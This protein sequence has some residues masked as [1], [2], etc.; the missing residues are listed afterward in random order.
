MGFGRHPPGPRLGAW[1]DGEDQVGD[2]GGHVARCARCR[3]SVSEMAR[4]R[5]WMR[6]QPFFAMSDPESHPEVPSSNRRPRVVAVSVLLVLVLLVFNAPR[7]RGPER[8]SRPDVDA[9]SPLFNTGTESESRT[10]ATAEH[11]DQGQGPGSKQAVT[12]S[13][14]PARKDPVRLGLVVPTKGPAAKEG[15]EVARAVRGRVDQANGAG[16]VGGLPVELVVAAAE[17]RAAVAALSKRVSALVGGFGAEPPPGVPWLFPADPSVAGA[18]IVPAEASPEVAGQ[19]LGEHLR[20]QSVGGPVGVVVGTGPES[21]LAAG[22]ASRVPTT[23]VAAASGSSCAS[24]VATLRRDG[25]VALAVAGPP[26]LAARCLTSAARALWAPRFGTVVA[27]SAAYAGL[28]NVT[29]ARGARTVLG[30]PW[31]TSSGTGTARFRAAVGA[32]SYRALVSFAATE[33]ALDVARRRGVVS[34]SSLAGG[35]WRSD[36]FEVSGTAIRVLPVVASANAWAPAPQPGPA[37]PLPP[38]LPVPVPGL[39]S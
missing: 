24:E 18:S 25:A 19:Q 16:G 11:G 2:I 26:D 31:P 32:G 34:V 13:D 17:D 20:A 39:A 12:G 28:E 4:V 5:S 7:L 1:F 27:P 6:A 21:S 36:L 15:T 35:V 10:P 29:E 3:R 33:L 8:S 14:T 38:L 22:L 23:T 30:L 9:S 37:P